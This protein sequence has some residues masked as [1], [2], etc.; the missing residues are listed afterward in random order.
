MKN[1][2]PKTPRPRTKRQRERDNEVRAIAR[3]ETRKEVG[4]IATKVFGLL[5]AVTLEMLKCAKCGAE[6]GRRHEDKCV[7]RVGLSSRSVF[8]TAADCEPATDPM[9]LCRGCRQAIGQPHLKACSAARPH[10]ADET[11][12]VLPS[13]CRAKP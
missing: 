5:A 4:R 1:K 6:Q 11:A 12:F 8:V 2:T 13:E 7:T 9:T 3:E 10:A